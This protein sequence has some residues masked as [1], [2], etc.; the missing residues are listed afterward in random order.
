MDVTDSDETGTEQADNSEN[1]LHSRIN[2][3]AWIVAATSGVDLHPLLEMFRCADC[4]VVAADTVRAWFKT[5]PHLISIVEAAKK[6]KRGGAPQIIPVLD[7]EHIQM[8]AA[9]PVE[10]CGFL[11]LQSRPEAALLGAM[12]ENS[13]MDETLERWKMS[14]RSLLQICYRNRQTAAVLSYEILRRH[15]QKFAHHLRRRLGIEIEGATAVMN[16]VD[17]VK[18]SE[19]SRLVA[20]QMV[21]QSADVRDVVGELDACLPADLSADHAMDPIDFELVC[22]ELVQNQLERVE[23]AEEN[24]LLLLQLHQVQE[25]LDRYYLELQDAEKRRSRLK[26]QLTGCKDKLEKRERELE[27]ANRKIEGFRRSNSWRITLPMRMLGGFVRRK[28]K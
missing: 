15:P 17:V 16:A 27:S 23:L 22:E 19:A 7:L 14:A 8:L 13:S 18:V 3:R 2:Q 28:R 26:M 24:D 25:E 5:S 12:A 10:G 1:Q 20:M 4:S 21:S 11:L 9:T 6:E